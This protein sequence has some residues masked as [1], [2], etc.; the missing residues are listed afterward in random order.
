M[1]SFKQFKFLK[2][3]E[4]SILVENYHLSRIFSQAL[5]WISTRRIYFLHFDWLEKLILQRN[6]SLRRKVGMISTFSPQNTVFRFS[7]LFAS[8]TDRNILYISKTLFVTL[9]LLVPSLC[10]I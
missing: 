2:T 4:K 10:I 3:R 1:I 9:N 8:W 7:E 6:I 5:R